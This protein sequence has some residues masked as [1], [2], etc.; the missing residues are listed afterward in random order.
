MMKAEAIEKS[1]FHVGVV[2]KSIFLKSD[3]ANGFTYCII[4]KNDIDQ[5]SRKNLNA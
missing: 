1:L 4:Q 3:A 5:F 2:Q